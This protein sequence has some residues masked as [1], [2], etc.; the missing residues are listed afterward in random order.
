[1]S[2]N[3][4]LTTNKRTVAKQPTVKSKRTATEQKTT[5][6]PKAHFLLALCVERPI[7]FLIEQFR[8][9]RESLASMPTQQISDRITF[10]LLEL[11]ERV[12]RPKMTPM[13]LDQAAAEE[14]ATAAITAANILEQLALNS[15]GRAKNHIS[16]VAADK[17]SWPVNLRLGVR[18]QKGKSEPT[19]ERAK[20]AK[21]YLLSIRLGQSSPPVLK[22]LQTPGAKTI[23]KRAAELLLHHLHDWQDNGVWREATRE[24]KCTQW[25][26][27]LLALDYPMTTENVDGWW[28][29]AKRWM[30]EQWKINQSYFEP[31]IAVCKTS[32]IVNESTTPYGVGSGP[33]KQVKRK[34]PITDAA[35]YP[36]EPRSIVID[37]RLKEAFCAL[38]KPADL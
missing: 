19:L 32:K 28:S 3:G 2:I 18:K 35:L 13:G 6:A 27:D 33:P 20:E 21:A 16:Y 29:V 30:D 11:A 25:S 5:G 4:N 31:L 1:M 26:K 17:N 14:L 23:F 10:E 24:G 9:E 22:H 36:C 38:A 34:V 8:H 12:I 7:E 37:L 15:S